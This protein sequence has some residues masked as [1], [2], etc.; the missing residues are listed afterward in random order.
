LPPQYGVSW[1]SK[2]SAIVS[3]D[4]NTIWDSNLAGLNANGVYHIEVNDINV[5]TGSHLLGIGIRANIAVP[6]QGYSYI[7]RWDSIRFVTPGGI[8]YP[9]VDFNHDC[10]VDI[11]DLL[12]FAD[13]WLTSDGPDLN[14]DGV[15]DLTDFAIFANDW[16]LGC[17]AVSVEPNFIDPP[18]T[19]FNND[20]VVDYSDLLIFGEEWLGGGGPCVRSDLNEDGIVDFVDFALFAK[21]WQ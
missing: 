13:A 5:A 3:I 8:V 11:Y 17:T 20:G 18:Q 1:D 12:T 19:D 21:T 15:D 2:F 14:G 7:A 4:G 9:P 16:M 10:V 6:A